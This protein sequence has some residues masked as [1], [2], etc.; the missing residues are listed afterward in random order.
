MKRAEFE[1]LMKERSDMRTLLERFSKMGFP[2]SYYHSNDEFAFSQMLK[3]AK[4]LVADSKQSDEK[5]L[6][7]TTSRT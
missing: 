6:S 1:L 7:H 4:Q 2:R 3:A 5:L